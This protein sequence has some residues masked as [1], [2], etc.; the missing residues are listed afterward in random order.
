MS[1]RTLA[2][3][4]FAIAVSAGCVRLGFWQISR[5]HQRRALNAMLAE[6]RS[7]APRPVREVLRDTVAA[8][9]RRATATGTYDYAN[10]M[11]LAARTH[12]GAPGVN[13]ITPL[14]LAGTD[15]AVLVNRGWVYAADAMTADLARWR[16][17]DTATVTG[18]LIELAEPAPGAV[19]T[20]S[21][22]RTIRRLDRD[23]VARRL[24]YPIVPFVLVATDVPPE[25][26][27]SVPPRV[28]PPVLDDGPHLGYAIQWFM[29]AL[30]GLLGAGFGVRADRR[31]GGR[32]GRQHAL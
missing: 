16:E 22:P 28:L 31:G 1:R 17:P 7:A 19:S 2:F 8:S 24:P 15:S 13:V 29:F 10:E 27:D 11:A 20:P 4:L 6:R 26:A 9:Y 23:S 18:Y 12:E 32:R 25:S 30:I 3:V 14:R 5:L 21:N